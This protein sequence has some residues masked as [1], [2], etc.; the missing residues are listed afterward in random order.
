[1]RNGRNYRLIE[2]A[3]RELK[4]DGFEFMMYGSWYDSWQK[5]ASDI[6]GM[7]I[8]IPVMHV[9]KRVGERITLGET[10]EARRVFRINCEMAAMLG[11]TVP[12]TF[13]YW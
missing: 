1:M 8:N 10:E 5:V 2:K 3:A 4:C 7:G 12:R 13:R 6:R 11:H 9:E